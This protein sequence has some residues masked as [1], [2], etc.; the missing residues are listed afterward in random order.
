MQLATSYR[1]LKKGGLKGGWALNETF[2]SLTD[3]FEFCGMFMTDWVVQLLV[4]DRPDNQGASLRMRGDNVSALSW[5][6][7]CEG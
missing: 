7:R 4:G 1:E 2:T 3:L 5:V 6:N